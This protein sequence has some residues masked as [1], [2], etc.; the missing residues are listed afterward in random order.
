MSTYP[1][2]CR[3]AVR[4]LQYRATRHTRPQSFSSDPP[5]SPCGC[6]CRSAVF[7]PH[8]GRSGYTLIEMMTVIVLIGILA[9]LAIPHISTAQ[10]KVDGATY[11]VGTHLLAAQRSAVMK[12]H[13][14]VVAFDVNEGRIR[15]HEDV[16]NDG[17]IDRTENVRYEPLDEGI[18]FGRGA[19]PAHDWI[20]QETVS[21][22]RMQDGLPA[23]SFRRNG[24]T[25]EQGGFYLTTRRAIDTGTHPED[26]RAV[27]IS[28]A[29]GRSS[30]FHYA[31][32]EWQGGF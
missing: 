11:S 30:W 19:A 18:V 22:S 32:P 23:V 25:A 14:V 28:R 13:N 2:D 5:P 6:R 31:A 29:T 8:Q 7:G 24:S 10:Y 16:D 3:S 27:I 15:I 12:Q 21:F 9:S 4:R 1:S 17:M 26:A 20:G